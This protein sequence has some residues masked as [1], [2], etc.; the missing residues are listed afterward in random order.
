MLIWNSKEILNVNNIKITFTKNNKGRYDFEVVQNNISLFKKEYQASEKD[1]TGLT[2][3]Q[4]FAGF[5]NFL[6]DEVNKELED[7]PSFKWNT[8]SEFKKFAGAKTQHKF[9]ECSEDYI[10]YPKAGENIGPK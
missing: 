10:D 1:E 5:S 7:N 3:A 8:S 2:Q 4:V 9:W 6:Q